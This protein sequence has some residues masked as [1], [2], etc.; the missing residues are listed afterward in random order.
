MWDNRVL[1]LAEARIPDQ[2]EQPGLLPTGNKPI[3]PGDNVAGT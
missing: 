2:M 1:F 3:V